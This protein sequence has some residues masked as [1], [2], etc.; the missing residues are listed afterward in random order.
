[1]LKLARGCLGKNTIVD[2]DGNRI[3]WHYLEKLQQQQQN[4]S[5]KLTKAHMQWRSRKMNVRLA[6][7]TLSNSVA[8]SL[9]FMRT[10]DEEFEDV[11][12]T[13]KYI[14]I[15]NDVFDIMN[16]TSKSTNATSFKRPIDRST[17][18]E[19]FL[20][21]DEAI[22]YIKQLSI[23]GELRSILKSEHYTPFMGF[24]NNMINFKH[25]FQKYVIEMDKLEE[26]VTHRHCQDHL[27]SFFGCIRSMGG[28]NDN[29]TSQQLEAS[30]RKLLI[31]NEV[32]CSKKSNTIE[33]GTRILTVS[34]HRPAQERE[35]TLL[36]RE[37][38]AKLEDLGDDFRL[39][40][41]ASTYTDGITNHS[42]A[43]MAS[44]VEKKKF[45]AKSPRTPINMA[46]PCKS[47]FE[48]CRYIDSFLKVSEG[49]S[50]I[51]M[52]F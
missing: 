44:V 20:K 2:G 42:L 6:A 14:R 27:E 18:R 8:D 36:S 50:S 37:D 34:S 47:T 16:S 26:I 15:F 24:I 49:S 4:L 51:S 31:H 52:L 11:G 45:H 7:E 17:Y 12:P 21:F 9:E 30:Y 22:D 5:N 1:M 38:M 23:D 19:Y 10:V 40:Y 13:A 3:E 48:I 32:V 35:V 43:F 39:S 25:I 33:I 28:F 46:Q 41:D 29:P